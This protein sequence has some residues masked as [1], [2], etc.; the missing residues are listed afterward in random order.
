MAF[1]SKYITYDATRLTNKQKSYRTR[2]TPPRNWWET[3]LDFEISVESVLN[4][5]SPI[6][7]IG[8]IDRL[9]TGDSH[10]TF[11]PGAGGHPSATPVP[12]PAGPRSVKRSSTADRDRTA[13]RADGDV[14][15]QQ[16]AGVR[17]V[18]LQIG[19]CRAGTNRPAGPRRSGRV[20]VVDDPRS[21][22]EL[23]RYF[24]EQ[25]RF[26]CGDPR[27]A[28]DVASRRT[29]GA[30]PGP[31]TAAERPSLIDRRLHYLDRI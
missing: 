10:A 24:G 30:A 8:F 15:V 6:Q 12:R 2:S 5:C 21:V 1:S 13:H 14:G 17:R 25:R 11:P 18:S 7:R 29:P 23:G 27:P 4:E 26:A 16:P 3:H 9:D 31:A 22:G 19:R 28:A 20:V